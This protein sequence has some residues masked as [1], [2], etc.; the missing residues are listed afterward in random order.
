MNLPQAL[1]VNMRIYL[2]S[3]YIHVS[4]HFLD[5]SQISTAGQKVRCETMS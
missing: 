1:P 4:E 5:A 3:G 2:G